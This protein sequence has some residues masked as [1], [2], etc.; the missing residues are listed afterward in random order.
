LVRC[1]YRGLFSSTSGPK[2]PRPTG[3][4]TA[5]IEAIVELKPRNPRFGCPRIARIISH[6]FVVDI[7]KNVVYR[8]L[9]KRPQSY[10]IGR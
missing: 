3:P 5:L 2:K 6:T 7:D 1:K 10:N 8:V 9:A 4:S